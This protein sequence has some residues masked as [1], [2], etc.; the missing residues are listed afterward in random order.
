MKYKFLRPARNFLL[1]IIIQLSRFFFFLL[2][3]DFARGLGELLGVVCFY[4][5]KRERDKIYNNLDLVYPG[6]YDPSAKK[7]FA[8]ANFKN[9]GR[10][11][12]E[13]AKINIWPVSKSASLV[14]EV[15]GI[16]HFEKAFREKRGVVVVT[17]H[18]SNWELIPVYLST[19]GY[20]LG[21]VAKKIFDPSIDR[22][23]NAS[24]QKTG[25]KVFDRDKAS[26]DLVKE[27]RSG[28]ILG[29]LAD[30]D[31]RVESR[32]VKFLGVDAKTPIAPASLAKRF[33][34][35]ITTIFM[36]RRE[37]GFYKFIINEPF[38]VTEKDSE[39]EIALR[40]NNAI[41]AMIEQYPHQWVWV[42]ERWKNKV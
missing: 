26:R 37:D 2:P 34:L 23:V 17:A 9:Y 27:L 35:P 28:M 19:K 8:M 12:A 22:I 40:Y 29:I 24:R 16:E 20:K 32:M 39:E 13:F 36:V 33:K 15:I 6:K 7:E 3:L 5:L 21:M 31:T 10:G 18:L 38:E 30:Q 11:M 25:A 42:H 14:K 41:S 1:I 4:L